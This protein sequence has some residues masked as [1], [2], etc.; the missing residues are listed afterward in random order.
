MAKTDTL[1]IRVEP[2]IKTKAENTLDDLGISITEAVNIFLHQIIL[3]QG[4]PFEIKKPKENKETI[5]ALAEAKK[6]LKDSNAKTYYT[7]EELM[8]DLNN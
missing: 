2:K 4:I 5:E 3:T 1:H 6:L 7:M 8:E